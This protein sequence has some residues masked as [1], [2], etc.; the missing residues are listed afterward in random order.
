[1]GKISGFV[2]NEVNYEYND[3]NY[4]PSEGGVPKAI[5]ETK[6]EAIAEAIKLA[7]ASTEFLVEGILLN[8]DNNEINVEK[9]L[10][11][12]LRK[13]NKQYLDIKDAIFDLDLPIEYN[14]GDLYFDYDNTLDAM[15][16]KKHADLFD[17]IA[18][19]NYDLL[20]QVIEVK[21]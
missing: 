16:N 18:E 10:R 7:R 8:G 20:F 3:E 21:A 12:Y 2:V 9:Y 6:E 13:I 17:L 15:K 11:K 5:F 19:S 4:T 1:M 14:D